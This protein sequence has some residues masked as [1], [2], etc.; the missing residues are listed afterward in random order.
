MS[1][2]TDETKARAYGFLLICFMSQNWEHMC[3]KLPDYSQLKKCRRDKEWKR[4]IME[5]QNLTISNVKLQ[6]SLWQK[7]WHR[8]L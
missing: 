1:F 5:C 4:E 3:Q 8:I 7:K 6:M 2:L